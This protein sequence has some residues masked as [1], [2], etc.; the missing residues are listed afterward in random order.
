MLRTDAPFCRADFTL[1]AANRGDHSQ[2][3]KPT[4]SVLKLARG[5]GAADDLLTM[6]GSLILLEQDGG[7]SAGDAPLLTLSSAGGIIYQERVPYLS[8][9]KVT[10]TGGIWGTEYLKGERDSGID[11]FVVKENFVIP[12][13][14]SDLPQYD[15]LAYRGRAVGLDLPGLGSGPAIWRYQYGSLCFTT[16]MACKASAISVRC[17]AAR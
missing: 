17:S 5:P 2:R 7:V 3:S 1:T 8:N 6:K 12:S 15:R 13:G 14:F 4:K 16:E 9:L 11:D 10:S